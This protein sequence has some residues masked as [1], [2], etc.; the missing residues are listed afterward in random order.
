MLG[1]APLM[2]GTQVAERGHRLGLELDDA[3]AAV[4]ALQR[5]LAA[6][7]GA[8]AGAAAAARAAFLAG[9]RWQARSTGGV[10]A[11]AARDVE[12]SGAKLKEATVE[13]AGACRRTVRCRIACAAAGACRPS[14]PQVLP[15]GR[16][17]CHIS[18]T[19]CCCG[20]PMTRTPGRGARPG[21]PAAAAAA[22]PP[23][24]RVCGGVGRARGGGRPHG[25]ARRGGGALRW[26]WGQPRGK[27]LR[28]RVRGRRAGA[29]RAARLGDPPPR[30]HGSA[31]RLGRGH[32]LPTSWAGASA[33]TGPCTRGGG[34]SSCPWLN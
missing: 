32:T 13:L 17:P 23:G 20:P 8:Q 12:E 14:V 4:E 11:R 10:I 31:A 34:R 2:R 6:A 24:A 1:A 7:H 27:L 28:V 29:G 21:V 33:V 22:A 30:T 9:A 26:Q 5:Q 16:A 19:P 25:G 3:C 18:S 15:R